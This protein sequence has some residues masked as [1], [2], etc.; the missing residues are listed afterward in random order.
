MHGRLRTLL[1]GYDGP[2]PPA[3]RAAARWGAGAWARL[4][5][6]ADAALLELRAR[7]CLAALARLRRATSSRGPESLDRLQRRGAGYRS[8]A[9][10][11]E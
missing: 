2:A 6:G 11:L 8:Q 5:R 10:M 4:A 1:L 7:G 3:E 9:V